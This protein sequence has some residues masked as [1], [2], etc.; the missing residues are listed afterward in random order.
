ME[1]YCYLWHILCKTWNNIA[2]FKDITSIL[3]NII[4]GVS[5][6]KGIGYLKGLKEKTNSATFNFWSQL[7]ARIKELLSWL[8]EDYN[9]LANM[10]EGVARDAWES[11]LGPKQERIK[12]FKQLVE[13]TL[14]FIKSTPDQ[15]PAYK[16]WT[17][18]YNFVVSFLNDVVQYDILNANEYF[19]YKGQIS[20]TERDRNC[21]EICDVMERLCNSITDKQIEIENKIL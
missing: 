2:S 9:L 1:F 11:E 7:R 20:K 5:I 17:N 13:E 6:I 16:G 14:K 12:Q 18:D 10:Y 3:L 19:K 4:T 8:R 21:Q 15:M